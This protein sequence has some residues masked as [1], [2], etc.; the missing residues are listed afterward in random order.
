M[1]EI[2]QKK[3]AQDVATLAAET[4]LVVGTTISVLERAFLLTYFKVACIVQWHANIVDSLIYG[5]AYGDATVADIQTALDSSVVNP[6]NGV[7][8]PANQV[9]ERV[10]IDFTAMECPDVIDKIGT[11]V[12]EPR[13]PKGGLPC[14]KVNGFKTFVYN[15]LGATAIT[16]GPNINEVMKAIGVWIGD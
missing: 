2:F 13:L 15:P 1:V 10:V 5:L 6:S 7:T 14:G 4:A 3:T 9:K 16:D 11:F 8:Y 12:W